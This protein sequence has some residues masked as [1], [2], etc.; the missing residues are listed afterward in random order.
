MLSR[1]AFLPAT[2][3]APV[4]ALAVPVLAPGRD[5]RTRLALRRKEDPVLR[6]PRPGTYWTCESHPR[7]PT[8]TRTSAMWIWWP[9]PSPCGPTAL[10]AASPSARYRQERSPPSRRGSSPS[11]RPMAPPGTPSWSQTA[12]APS[13]ASCPPYTPPR[14]SAATGNSYLDQ[15][16]S[17]FSSTTL[18]VDPQSLVAVLPRAFVG[19]VLVPPDDA[20]DQ[21]AP[22]PVADVPRCRPWPSRRCECPSSRSGAGRNGRAQWG[23]AS[24]ASRGRAGNGRTPATLAGSSQEPRPDLLRLDVAIRLISP[25]SLSSPGRGR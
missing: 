25:L 2:A 17:R 1:R 9:R 10:R 15:I 19:G 5:G 4:A 14:T 13:C 22:V 16:W 12:T 21:A 6:Q 23:S 11:A 18:T 20:R 3:T 7:A 24:R 8:C